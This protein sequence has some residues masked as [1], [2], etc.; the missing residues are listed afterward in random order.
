MATPNDK[1]ADPQPDVGR[2]EKAKVL[3]LLFL[4]ALLTLM[5]TAVGW[6]YDPEFAVAMLTGGLIGFLASLWMAVVLLRP[7][8]VE[9]PGRLL[10]A[11]YVGEI[12]KY[13]FV[14][15][16]FAIAFKK[17]AIVREPHNALLMMGAFTATQLVIWLWPLLTKGAG[18]HRE[19]RS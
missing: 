7:S 18:R 15:A 12:G 10:G 11:L 3:R 5:M 14:M 1:P 13:L 2:Q 6:Y 4:Q 8:A 9:T 19:D 17:I 16:F